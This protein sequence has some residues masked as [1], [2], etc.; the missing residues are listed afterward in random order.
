MLILPALPCSRRDGGVGAHPV[1]LDEFEAHDVLQFPQADGAGLQRPQQRLVQAESALHDAL[2]PAAPPQTHQL[3]D[4]V[5]GHL[6]GKQ[7]SQQCVVSPVSAAPSS[8]S[9][10]VPPSLLPLA[11]WPGSCSAMAHPSPR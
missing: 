5:A 8:S 10:A 2:Q 7:R 6:P 11:A 9:S 3:A 4:L 1:A